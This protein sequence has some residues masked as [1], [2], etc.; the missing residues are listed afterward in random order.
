MLADLKFQTKSKGHKTVPQLEDICGRIGLPVEGNMNKPITDVQ[1][2]GLRDRQTDG[3][4]WE[5]FHGMV[6]GVLNTCT[7]A[8]RKGNPVT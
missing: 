7:F 3:A 2:V 6:T 5:S 1:T 4:L 8:S